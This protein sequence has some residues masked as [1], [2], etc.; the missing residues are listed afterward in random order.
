MI[1]EALQYIVG[2]QQPRVEKIK[3]KHYY[4]NNNGTPMLL[5]ECHTCDALEISTLT[6]LVAYIKERMASDFAAVGAVPSMIVHVESETEVRLVSVFN[7]DMGRWEIAKVKARVPQISLNK[8]MDQESFI[9]Q[10][11]SMFIET[12]DKAIVMQVAG[13]VEDKTIA[14]YG[15]DGV[16]QKATI[17]TGLA[18][19]EDVFV[20][21]PVTLKPFRTF[22]EIDQP[23]IAFVFRMKNS[24]NGVSCA[25]FEADGGV[26]KFNAVHGIAQYLKKELYDV[27]NVAVLS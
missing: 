11:Q 22:H 17:K 1:K 20:P 16:T 6:S 10:M 15:D 7:G 14:N 4:F 12:P 9:I 2:L 23:E 24:Q 3:D 13:N 19:M 26:W 8:F 25:L 18:G 27:E 5:S 21:N